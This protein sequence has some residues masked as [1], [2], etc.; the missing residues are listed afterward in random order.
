MSKF[1]YDTEF[2]EGAQIRR[3]L[4]IPLKWF[5]KNELGNWESY[6]LMTKPTIDL[7]AIAVVSD[8]QSTFFGLSNEFNLREAWNRWQPKHGTTEK[9]YVTIKEY[10]IR[11]NVLR[12]IFDKYNVYNDEFTYDH[13]EW[14]V[15]EFG[16]SNE[17][18]ATELKRF[19]F[20]FYTAAEK[21]GMARG[22]NLPEFYGYYSAYD[23]VVMCWLFGVMNN[24]PK[25]FPWYTKDLKQSLDEVNL[26]LLQM[27]STL[28]GTISPEE[29]LGDLKKF[30]DYPSNYMEHDCLSDAFFNRDLYV[31][32]EQ[33]KQKHHV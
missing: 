25:Y 23:H 10:W 6:F 29:H 18:I 13:M 14:I 5:R 33:L 28:V 7:I 22:F 17:E 32:I 9:N 31:F 2:L 3:F 1:F 20:S 11:E 24:L 27:N 19:I 21:E 4:G 30:D 12:P 15:K 16:K 8:D 26:K